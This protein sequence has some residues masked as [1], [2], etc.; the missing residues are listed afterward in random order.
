MRTRSKDKDK[1][2]GGASKEKQ[3]DN[4]KELEQIMEEENDD[5]SEIRERNKKFVQKLDLKAREKIEGPLPDENVGYFLEQLGNLIGQDYYN[6]PPQG[7]ETKVKELNELLTKKVTRKKDASLPQKILNAA[8]KSRVDSKEKLLSVMKDK[9]INVSLTDAQK[10]LFVEILKARSYNKLIN[11]GDVLKGKS[12]Y[13]KH[14]LHTMED[15]TLENLVS[16]V[17]NDRLYLL[18]LLMYTIDLTSD[19]NKD[20]PSVEL[21]FKPKR[22]SIQSIGINYKKGEKIKNGFLQDY[23]DYATSIGETWLNEKSREIYIGFKDYVDARSQNPEDQ[24]VKKYEKECEENNIDINTFMHNNLRYYFLLKDDDNT[25]ANEAI[26]CIPEDFNSTIE[27]YINTQKFVAKDK[28]LYKE[29]IKTFDL[30][31]QSTVY[32][33][34]EL[35]VVDY[36]PNVIKFDQFMSTAYIL[37]SEVDLNEYSAACWEYDKKI[38]NK[39]DEEVPPN[40]YFYPNICSFDTFDTFMNYIL[41]HILTHEYPKAIV[42]RYIDS[43]TYYIENRQIFLKISKCL[44]SIQKFLVRFFCSFRT[45]VNFDVCTSLYTIGKKILEEFQVLYDLN[46]YKYYVQFIRTY[47]PATKIMYNAASDESNIIPVFNGCMQVLAQLIKFDRNGLVDKFRT[48]AVAIFRM[49]LGVG[50]PREEIND[51]VTP[52]AF[53]G[54]M[55][56]DFSK[57]VIQ[58][59]LDVFFNQE[60]N[61][62]VDSDLRAERINYFMEQEYNNMSDAIEKGFASYVD[63]AA[64]GFD[65][66]VLYTLFDFFMKLIEKPENKEYYDKI[67]NVVLSYFIETGDV[68]YYQDEVMRKALVAYMI[69]LLKE[70]QK[71]GD[72]KIELYNKGVEITVGDIDPD[73]IQ[74]IIDSQLR[75]KKNIEVRKKGLILS[76]RKKKKGILTDIRKERDEIVEKIR[77]ELLQRKREREA[78][79]LKR[80]KPKGTAK[81]LI[82]K[83]K[84]LQDNI[85]E[86]KD[87]LEENQIQNKI[88]KKKI[89]KISKKDKENMSAVSGESQQ[90]IAS[91]VK[92]DKRTAVKNLRPGAYSEGGGNKGKKKYKSNSPQPKTKKKDQSS[93]DEEIGSDKDMD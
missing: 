88:L 52:S 45:K 19:K 28:K 3:K 26:L 74:N 12:L 20:Q 83:M 25:E 38:Y 40:P 54:N 16:F 27:D 78:E 22:V 86:L 1:N 51:Y 13:V 17:T 91:N 75:R 5:S 65:Y 56:G 80:K 87:N 42:D 31:S 93:S 35:K 4:A 82:N 68:P 43:Y 85:D 23:V 44:H 58:Q 49:F 73:E 14:M 11:V 59:N 72:E 57:T 76:N 71:D 63:Q 2:T 89:V 7:K 70:E 21:S 33:S 84:D 9:K 92:T 41:V 55:T 50:N 69:P 47:L 48:C 6:E 46:I 64:K 81:K 15:D 61:R 66:D 8:A 53:L 36:M 77:K 67:R 24:N 29:G 10:D 37:T 30:K 32:I 62:T 18:C 34:S 39:K 60:T 79:E 90:S